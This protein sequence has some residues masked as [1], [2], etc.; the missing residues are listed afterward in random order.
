[1]QVIS[2][3]T[4]I[5]LSLL[6][7]AADPPCKLPSDECEDVMNNSACYNGAVSR[8]NLKGLLECFPQGMTEVRHMDAHGSACR[9]RSLTWT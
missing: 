1:M 9:G 2:L 6:T 3:L 7:V 4:L 8:K 5:S